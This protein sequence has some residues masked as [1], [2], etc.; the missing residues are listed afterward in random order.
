[1][2]I[3]LSL[4]MFALIFCS[5]ISYAEEKIPV[6]EKPQGTLITAEGKVSVYQEEWVAASEYLPVY[7]KNIVKT[8]E[9]S[10]AEIM[11]DD[12]T[13]IR[14]EE[15]TKAEILVKD[16]VPEISLKEGEIT[17]SVVP[18]QQVAFNVSS[19]LA[20]IGV[21]GTE[22]TVSHRGEKTDVAVYKG[23]VEVSDRTKK[24]KKILV[25]GGRQTFIFKKSHPAKPIGLSKKY[26]KYRKKVLK[27]FIKRT[28]KNRQN[29]EKILARRMEMIKKR[30]KRIIENIKKRK[31]SPPKKRHIQH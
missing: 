11:L 14:F 1:M 5:L 26:K 23:A 21:R 18:S 9:N 7:P 22:F 30:N 15:K 25:K 2:K 16:G 29:K 12:E 19:P 8:D 4:F 13:V 20:I 3:K 24:P 6:Q 10:S 28:I 31:I 17:S 27:K